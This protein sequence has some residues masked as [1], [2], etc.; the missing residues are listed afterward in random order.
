MN[1]A[2]YIARRLS[3]GHPGGSHRS[4]AA[5]IAVAGIALSVA[6][7]LLTVA[8][9]PGF[10]HAITRKVMG[11]DAQI[12]MTP[13]RPLA[14]DEYSSN[15]VATL[16]PD[17]TERLMTIAPGADARLT[18]RQP[19]LLKTADQYQALVFK[20][21]E[22]SLED[23][24]L[25]ENLEEGYLPD[26]SADS[27]RN[28]IVISRLTADALALAP[29]DRVDAAFFT[30]AAL[31]MRRYRIAGIYNS[32]FND[33]DRLMAFMSL[34]EGESVA[35]LKQG[36][37]TAIELRDIPDAELSRATDAAREAASAMFHDGSAGCYY[38]VENVYQLNP[39]Y[40]NWLDL[41]DTN[42]VI[43]LA[44]MGCVAAA[45][46]ISCLFIMILE[47]VR[48]IGILKALG[49][50]N[51]TVM[52]LFLSLAM[53]VVLRGL[54]YGNL[55]AMALVFVQWRW[56]LLPLDPESYYLNFVPVE[57]A[58]WSFLTVDVA[59]VVTSLLVMLLPARIAAGISPT[60]VMR[61]E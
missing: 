1:V 29:G 37:G 24:F 23:T 35:G 52:Q 6:V 2:Y 11:F 57:W 27:T 25:A 48:M 36:E 19:G 14:A 49:A 16:S 40:F 51:R 13:L 8:I 30:D 32:H 43:I 44:L 59:V 12:V 60:K 54:L 39:I 26:Y 15:S 41:L 22:G 42:V 28:D 17:I 4:P 53:K 20:A 33:Y 34:R 46:L 10:K 9:V 5:S 18:V 45:T 56:H 50:D 58:W 55:L 3:P 31:K 38:A 61:F 21:W 47:R 7:M